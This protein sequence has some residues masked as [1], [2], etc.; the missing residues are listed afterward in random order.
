MRAI[1][2]LD[3]RA[4]SNGSGGQPAGGKTREPYLKDHLEA[5]AL[6]TIRQ[7]FTVAKALRSGEWRDGDDAAPKAS[8]HY[9][10]AL[11][12]AIANSEWHRFASTS[13]SREFFYLLSERFYQLYYESVVRRFQGRSD[14]RRSSYWDAYFDA[15]RDFEEARSLRRFNRMLRSGVYAHI[16]GDLH[17]AIATT[18]AWQGASANSPAEI[19]RLRN[20]FLGPRSSETIRRITGRFLRV[21]SSEFRHPGPVRFRRF[22]FGVGKEFSGCGIRT[23][24]SWRRGA[25]AKAQDAS[26]PA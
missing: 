25:W 2:F 16:V 22:I 15:V 1:A 3:D 7:G 12:Y 5:S 14:F 23:V 24:Q 26:V 11:L 9:Y 6:W 17:E 4:F 8:N 18:L 20:E 21:M 19:E 13:D 10:F